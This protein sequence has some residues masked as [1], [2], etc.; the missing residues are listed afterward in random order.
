[1]NRLLLELCCRGCAPRLPK[2]DTGLQLAPH[3]Y[4]VAADR[5]ALSSWLWRCRLLC[6]HPW[7]LVQLPPAVQTA[8][9]APRG[10]GGLRCWIWAELPPNL[11]AALNAEP[12]PLPPEG[13]SL[14][15]RRGRRVRR[16]TG[17]PLQPSAPSPCA[18]RALEAAPRGGRS[19][20]ALPSARTW[21]PLP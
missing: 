21:H 20:S 3:F 12:H 18:G 14:E 2:A 15:R 5:H 8:R 16:P 11:P 1:M 9:G 6:A 10:C 7:V 4:A 13:R 19:G 17:F